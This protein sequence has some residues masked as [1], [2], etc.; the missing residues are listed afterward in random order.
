MPPGL[1]RPKSAM[2]RSSCSANWGS[3]GGS[4]S[5][6][7]GTSCRAIAAVPSVTTA[8]MISSLPLK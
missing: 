1:S 3:G 6:R 8:L 7:M 5:F 4:G 2:V